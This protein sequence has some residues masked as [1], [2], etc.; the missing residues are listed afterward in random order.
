MAIAAA[1]GGRGTIRATLSGMMKLYDYWESGNGYKVRLLL[2]QLGLDYERIELD[3]LSGETRT[4]DIALY[5]YTHV[6]GEGGFE[7]DAYPEIRAW[8]ERVRGQAG[9]VP[10]QAAR[11]A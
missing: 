8:L 9:H 5:A 4:D 6:A 1:H 7:L 3:I 2:A 10:L 11:P